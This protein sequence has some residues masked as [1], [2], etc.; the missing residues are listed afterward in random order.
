MLS[1]LEIFEFFIEAYYI[2]K[3]KKNNNNTNS[4]NPESQNE[5]LNETEEPTHINTIKLD[6]INFY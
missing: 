2:W 1:F 3:N 6:E 5:V 4:P